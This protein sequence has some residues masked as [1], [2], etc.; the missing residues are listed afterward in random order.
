MTTVTLNTTTRKVEV[1]SSA[2]DV[3]ARAYGHDSKV[4]LQAAIVP[5][6]I[7]QVFLRGYGGAGDG[8]AAHYKRAPSE[9]SHPGKIQS[10]DGAW[11]EIDEALLNVAMFGAGGAAFQAAVDTLPGNGGR[12]V[13]PAGDYSA[14]NPAT[15]T[16]GAKVITWVADRGVTLPAD[17]PGAVLSQGL[18]SIN[19][20]SGNANRDGD[21]FWHVDLGVRE[22]DTNNRDRAFHVAGRLPDSGDAIERV[23]AAYSFTLETDSASVQS[24]DIRGVYGLCAADGGQAN[25]RCIRVLA[26][27]KNGHTGNLTGV[28]GTVVHTDSPND[29]VGAVGDAVAMRGTVGAGCKAAFMAGAFA[30]PQRPSFAFAVDTG[31]ATPLRPENSCYFAHGGGNGDLFRGRRD[32]DG[33]TNGTDVIFSVDNKARIMARSFYSGRA[34]IADDAVTVIADPNASGSTGFFRFWVRDTAGTYGEAYYRVNAS[35]VCTQV[36]KGSGAVTFTTGALTGTTGADGDLTVSAH[37]DGNIYLENR[38]GASS[39][40]AWAFTATAAELGQLT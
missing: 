34:T 40:V 15:L 29:T 4:A 27:G 21:V 26:E 32:I 33:A 28:L 25:V 16:V 20:W 31:S 2:R 18:F 1:F 37:S 8:G 13:V 6:G 17:M 30:A 24:G 11:W 36:F 12:I 7:D 22:V 19:N 23:M 35:P 14:I 39:V 5:V 3:Q 9:P 38:R 10:A